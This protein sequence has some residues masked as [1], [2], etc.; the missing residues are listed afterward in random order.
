MFVWGGFG[1]DLDWGGRVNKYRK[2]REEK[3]T[4]GERNMAITIFIVKI[5]FFPHQYRFR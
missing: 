4:E 1:K 5:I 2:E 3:G